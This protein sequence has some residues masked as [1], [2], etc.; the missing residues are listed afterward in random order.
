MTFIDA[1]PQRYRVI[2][3]DIWG[4]VH[5]GVNLYPGSAERLLQWRDEGRTIILI[6]NAPR[7]AGAVEAQLGRIGLPR[8]AWDG[9]STSGEAG[10]AALKALNQQVGFIGTRADREILESRGLELVEVGFSQLVCTG[11]DDERLRVEEYRSQLEALSQRD[12][13]LHCLN[14]DR[15]V[16]RGGETEPCAGALAD[17]YV[18]LG[19]RVEW[20]GKPFP[21]IYR[22]AL[23]LAG[24][25]PASE[26]IAIGD[27]LQTDI[28][29][30][31]RMGF[32]AIF[33]TG[34]IHAGE[35]FPAEFGLRNGVGDW[36][37]V[38][39]VESLR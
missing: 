31:A 36:H 23:G 7:T 13:L 29:G 9:I 32:D 15:I 12:T 25:P 3:C 37:P 1:L 28:L 18:D 30:A 16:V 2:L 5:D 6:T 17:V 35:T 21:T 38:A 27:S 11:L 10:I 26:V 14:P 20:Y 19:G 4:V 22:H 34:G 33:V 24:D 39:V 8:S